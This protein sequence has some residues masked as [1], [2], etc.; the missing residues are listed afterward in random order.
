MDDPLPSMF[1]PLGSTLDVI[2]KAL[3]WPFNRMYVSV[4]EVPLT[5]V[6]TWFGIPVTSMSLCALILGAATS[7][8]FHLS[9][10]S[11]LFFVLA[12]LAWFVLLSRGKH[13]DFYSLSK[14]ALFGAIIGA[15]VATHVSFRMN[16]DSPNPEAVSAWYLI[17]YLLTQLIVCYLKAV[18]RRMR[19]GAALSSS[20]SSVPRL[21][22]LV[23]FLNCKGFM[24]FESFPSGDAAGAMCFSCVL[25]AVT[26][27]DY[28]YVFAAV[29]S[30][31]RMYFFAHHFI[32]VAVG[33]GIAYS[34]TR[35][36]GELRTTDLGRRIMI[37]GV[38]EE[39]N[40]WHC[41]VVLLFFAV[42]YGKIQKRFR[43]KDL[44]R[45]FVA[46]GKWWY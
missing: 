37:G 4:L 25:A 36:A 44:P 30:A 27:S 7:R 45:Q 22:P 24:V 21:F 18:C 31:G 43:M 28:A 35:A 19:P 33:A 2:D 3:T 17:S 23:T 13:D 5:V 1:P 14:N 46:K 16:P 15:Q 40:L 20:L 39:Y 9:L 10:L 29:A 12:L 41:V 6:G 42:A 32:D 8:T 26:Q 38:K 11:L 34:V